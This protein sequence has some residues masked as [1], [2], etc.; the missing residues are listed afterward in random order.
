MKSFL[1]TIETRDMDD[2]PFYQRPSVLISV[3]VITIGLACGVFFF[4]NRTPPL[5]SDQAQAIATE[6]LS[7]IRSG[8]VDQAWKETSADFKSMWGQMRFRTMIRSKPI[9]LAPSEF[10][11]CDFSTEG[12]LHV[13]HCRFRSSTSKGMIVVTLHPSQS[14]W[15]V[16]RLAVE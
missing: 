8:K 10:E 7:Q 5:S 6:F 11:K 13:A 4:W 15:Q 2:L 1:V 12:N 16:G 14:R 3:G 9:L